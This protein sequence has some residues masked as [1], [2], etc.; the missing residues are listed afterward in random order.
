MFALLALGVFCVLLIAVILPQLT[1]PGYEGPLNLSER[2]VLL[3]MGS[4]LLMAIPGG[5]WVQA[6]RATGLFVRGT[7]VGNVLNGMGFIC[8]VVILALGSSP[9]TYAACFLATSTVGTLYFIWD[10]RRMIPESRRISLS[11]TSAWAGRLHLSGSV[12]F[13]FMALANGLKQQG[14]ILVLG[15]TV[16]PVVVALY[17]THRTIVGLVT[18]ASSMIQPAVWPEMTFLDAQG[19]R[20]DLTRLLLL[21]TRLV[22]FLSCAAALVLMIFGPLLYPIWTDRELHF[23]PTLMTFFIIQIILSSGWNTAIW[24]LLAS[25]QHRK[26]TYWSLANSL[27]TIVVAIVLAPKFGVL[28]VASA[29]LA[30]DI[31]C[32]LVAFPWIASRVM[33]LP[34]YRIYQA[35][36]VPILAIIPAGIFLFLAES[37]FHGLLLA[38]VVSVIVVV[39]VYPTAYLAL[40]KG[41][42]VKWALEKFR[43]LWRGR[44]QSSKASV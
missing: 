12:H 20:S 14:V 22:V 29:G 31:V 34:I 5:V 19:R 26:I 39:F 40:G 4:A 33:G 21:T 11:L 44:A 2:L 10:V 9:M 24:S 17:A 8:Y 15:A 3:F 27:L 43:G 38:L 1:L 35:M 16:S 42:D 37:F 25:N 30:G 23:H 36:F 28:G 6:Y 7:M 32:G 41:E 18:Y 13:W